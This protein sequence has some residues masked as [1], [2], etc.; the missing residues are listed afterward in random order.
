M[1]EYLHHCWWRSTSVVVLMPPNLV[2]TRTLRLD[3]TTR[4]E[5]ERAGNVLLAGSSDA[6]ALVLVERA[7]VR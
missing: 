1:W 4:E 6:M 3:P 7:D 2:L 5:R